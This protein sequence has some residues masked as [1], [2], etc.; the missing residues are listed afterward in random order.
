M[1]ERIRVNVPGKP[2]WGVF[3]GDRLLSVSRLKIEAT[4][5]SDWC[6]YKMKPPI[7][8]VVRRVRIVVED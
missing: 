3:E 6:K 2:W 4:S 5:H 8:A 1:T 7:K